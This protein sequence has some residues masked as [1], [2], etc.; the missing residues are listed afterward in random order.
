MAAVREPTEL[1]TAEW[2]VTDSGRGA[3]FYRLTPLGRSQLKRATEDWARQAD[4]ISRI[5]TASL[6]E[7]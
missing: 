6:G 5:L 4:A 1:V 2:Q 7:L 3:K